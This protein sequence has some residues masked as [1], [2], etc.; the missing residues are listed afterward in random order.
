MTS[1]ERIKRILAHQP[2]DRIGLHEHFWSDTHRRWCAE[3]HV[4][5]TEELSDHFGLDIRHAGGGV[6]LTA[7]IDVEP[8]V[9]EEDDDTI[10]IR[11]G[12]GALLR[13]HKHQN[14]VPEH[15][16]FRVTDRAGWE[17]HI[18]PY[19]TFD[20]ARIDFEKYRSALEAGRSAD[21][22][23]VASN[24][25]VFEL[26][27]PVCG[28]EHML[29]GMVSDPEWVAN[30][31]M[32]YAH[33][34]INHYEELFAECGT[35]DAMWFSEDLGFRDHPFMSPTMYRELIKPA[36]QRTFD[37]AHS[38][39]LPVI[40]HS[41]GMMKAFIPDL[42]D[43]GM[44]CLQAMEVKAGMDSCEIKREFGDR[45]AL[46]GGIDVRFLTNNDLKGIDKELE[47]RIP[48]LMKDSGYVLHS[49]HSIPNQVN[50]ETYRYFLQR[51]LEIGTYC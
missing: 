25:N 14:G 40:I 46:I 36:H 43:A 22:F 45:I 10:L 31:A 30:M 29:V 18:A 48:D 5:E 44:D 21:M 12:N 34:L 33:L 11:D 20:R 39:N 7:R 47:R 9:V 16:D 8:E 19:L 13:K 17:E 35:P 1:H 32:T 24:R 26:I 49:D 50:Y 2:V 4:S 28:H 23:V 27:H 6:S 15:V 42:I 38:H 41:C 51:G 3:G 37:F